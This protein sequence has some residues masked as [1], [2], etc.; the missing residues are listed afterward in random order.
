MHTPWVNYSLIGINIVAFVATASPAGHHLGERLALFPLQP[1]WYEFLTY[2]F[3]H[4]NLM[5][6]FGNMIFL[7][8][9]GNN[10]EDRL[11]KIG[12]LAFYLGGGVIAGYG[13]CLASNAPVVGASGSV[14]AVTGAYLILFP[15]VGVTIFYWIFFYLGTF[16]VTSMVLIGLYIVL[17]LVQSFGGDTGVAYE[18]HLAGY[19]FGIAVAGGLLAVR[20]LPREPY[21]LLALLEHRRRRQRFRRMAHEGEAPWIAGNPPPDG[22]RAQPL[23]PQQQQLATLRHQIGAA[24]AGHDLQRA[25][26]L[27]QDL[28]RIDSRQVL[29][30]QQ[31]L[32][33]ANHLMS[34]GRH[35]VAAHAYEL[36]LQTYPMYPHREQVQLILGLIYARY[37]PRPQRARELL[38]AAL[39]RLNDTAQRQMAQSALDGLVPSPAGA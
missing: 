30:Q 34:A 28:L 24:I 19:A 15:K 22:H 17:N 20:L 27:Y 14:A 25:A 11:G 37:A 8:V 35:E 23:T 4:A 2:Q 10:L 32:D 7:Y 39:D 13:H 18:A 9:F 5:H 21:D 26:G 1:R 12:Y 38:T 31:Q 16:E 33:L 3:M 36:F 29:S 6:I